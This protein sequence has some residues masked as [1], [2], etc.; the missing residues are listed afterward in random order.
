MAFIAH[1]LAFQIRSD[2]DSCF[3]KGVLEKL[4]RVRDNVKRSYG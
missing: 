2:R 1:G 4:K 3:K